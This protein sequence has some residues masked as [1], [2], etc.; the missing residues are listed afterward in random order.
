MM[1]MKA[2]LVTQLTE[3][4]AEMMADLHMIYS[5]LDGVIDNV[6]S[7]TNRL[8]FGRCAWLGAF[9]AGGDPDNTGTP[10]LHEQF[11]DAFSV[12]LALSTWALLVL[13][14]AMIVAWTLMIVYRNRLRKP[15]T[16]PVLGARVPVN[17]FM[18]PSSSAGQIAASTV[19]GH[20]AW[21]PANPHYTSPTF[22]YVNPTYAVKMTVITADT[23]N[24][25]HSGKSD[26][27]TPRDETPRDKTPRD[28]KNDS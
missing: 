10:S 19:W 14:L 26:D 17:P 12:H 21:G 28:P 23:T 1:D 18:R 16:P 6:H 20:G 4:Q 22:E 9:W 3:M 24:H 27:K 8:E 15:K 25:H 7:K 11:C 13:V 5:S 2:M